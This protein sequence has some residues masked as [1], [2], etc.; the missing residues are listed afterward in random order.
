MTTVSTFAE[1]LA[2]IF[3]PSPRGPVVM[4][5]ELLE[6]CRDTEIEAVHKGE[7][8]E[9][10]RIVRMPDIELPSMNLG[11]INPSGFGG[12]STARSKTA[13]RTIK[14]AV[15]SAEVAMPSHIFRTVLARISAMCNQCVSE[16]ASPYGG[17]G[18][19]LF[20]AGELSQPVRFDITFSNTQT[21]K[22]ISIRRCS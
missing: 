7:S 9:F 11:F 4:T 12:N 6:F 18:T 20:A 14:V 8:C 13:S 5:N 3:T 22:S 16:T 21:D 2:A 19:I 1:S 15:E 17:T 10:K